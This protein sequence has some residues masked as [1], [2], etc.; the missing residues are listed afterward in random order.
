MCKDAT[1][2]LQ[3]AQALESDELGT[4]NLDSMP[5][6]LKEALVSIRKEEQQES[7]KKAAK[8]ILSILKSS[9]EETQKQIEAIRAARRAEALAK[10][11]LESIARA[12][13]YAEETSNYLPLAVLTGVF[14][15]GS[16]HDVDLSKFSVPMEW[17]PKAKKAPAKS[18]AK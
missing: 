15:A 5:E 18:T 8:L 10:S 16:L 9:D 12:K 1:I 14:R 11:K 13:A 7:M 17:K 4:Q 3:L 6:G 2:L